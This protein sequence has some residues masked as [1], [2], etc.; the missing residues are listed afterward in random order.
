MFISIILTLRTI[1]IHNK[2]L[3]LIVN[4]DYTLLFQRLI[5]V[6][7]VIFFIY[8]NCHI[9]YCVP[10]W[11]ET[12]HNVYIGI[13][14]SFGVKEKTTVSTLESIGM[15]T[16]TVGTM[17]GGIYIYKNFINPSLN[18][19]VTNEEILTEIQ[20]IKE[21]I[22][23]F[24]AN[25]EIINDNIG[26]IAKSARGIN[27]LIT[28]TNKNIGLQMI[29]IGKITT[30]VSLVVGEQIETKL[31]NFEKNITD[32][33]NNTND[34]IKESNLETINVLKLWLE[35]NKQEQVPEEVRSS[36]NELLS[37]LEN[38]NSDNEEVSGPI[39]FEFRRF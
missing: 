29:E 21:D 6:K 27:G 33:L 14:K 22:I 11:T 31:T 35:N 25:G 23:E 39:K 12:V 3:C 26:K 5:F 7:I 32:K 34:K 36:V 1:E 4:R 8:L 10:D 16:C 24:K 15:L 9:T 19:S 18:K 2:F 13:G 28:E 30:G 38:F 37:V 20:K 17:Y